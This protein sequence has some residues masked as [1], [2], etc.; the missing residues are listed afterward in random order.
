M[1]TKDKFSEICSYQSSRFKEWF[2]EMKFEK[3][4]TKLYSMKLPR[5]M[6]D[7][8]ILEELK[9]TEVSLGNIFFTLQNASKKDWMI[10]FVRDINGVLRA[11]GVNWSGDGWSVGARSVGY[12]DGWFA[13]CLVF[14]RNSFDTKMT[15]S[16]SDPL[17]L[18]N[19][20]KKLEDDM[21]KIRKVIN[22]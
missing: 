13:G 8:E 3:S 21:E 6:T 2:G 22:Y 9:P 19:R 7:Q 18:K 12:A 4:T 11:V 17:S 16:P 15:L 10:F 5:Y 14:S 20:V 1:K